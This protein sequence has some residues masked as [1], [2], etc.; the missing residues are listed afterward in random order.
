MA[1]YTDPVCKLCRR[2]GK[3]L[4]LKGEKCY[5][6]KCPVEKRPYAPGQHGKDRLKMTQYARQLRSKQTMK[7]T[8][9]VLERQFRRYF[10]EAVKTKGVTGTMLIRKV[11]SRL[12]NVVFRLGFAISRSHA[13]QL[14]NHGH[15]LVNGRRIDIPSYEL[16]PGDEI[17]LHEKIRSNTDVKKAIESRTSGSVSPWLEVNYDLFKGKFVRMPDREEL[18]L[19]LDVQDI[20]ELYSK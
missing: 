19:P 9:G 20:V 16:R 6:P 7:R 4:F 15:I 17:E 10:A 12:D 13:R 2:E 18:E 1:R 14:V 5:S 3:K 8:Y 11:E